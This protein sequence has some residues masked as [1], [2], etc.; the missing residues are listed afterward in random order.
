MLVVGGVQPDNMQ[1]WLDA[2]AMGFG[3]G[4]GLYKPGQTAEVTL[5]RARAYVAGVRR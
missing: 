4:G 1:P 5:R 3:L 2:G